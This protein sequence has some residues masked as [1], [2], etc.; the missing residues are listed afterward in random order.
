MRFAVSDENVSLD[1]NSW[2]VL[3]SRGVALLHMQRDA[4][5]LDCFERASLL[6]GGLTDNIAV[7]GFAESID[8]ADSAHSPLS[9]EAAVRLRTL[10]MVVADAGRRIEPDWVT[11][12]EGPGL[13]DMIDATAGTSIVPPR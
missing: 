7:V 12:K 9:P 11:V 13:A 4:E 3:F 5:A 2:T 1:G 10:I 6:D 8:T